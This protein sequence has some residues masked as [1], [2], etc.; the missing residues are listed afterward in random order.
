[1]TFCHILPSLDIRDGALD[2]LFNVYK[3]LL[4][5]FPSYITNH[6]GNVNLSTVDVI[7]AE[8]GAIEDY[9]FSM[10]HDNEERQKQRMEQ[11]RQ[12]KQ[13]AKGRNLDNPMLAAATQSAAPPKVLGKA[14]RILEKQ[15][16]KEEAEKDAAV[17]LKRGH[18]AKEE[19]RKDLKA[20]KMVAEANAKAALE[21]KKSL[22]GGG[23]KEEGEN[24]DGV[25]K[26]EVET[27]KKE[28]QVETA[29][30]EIDDASA[31]DKTEDAQE[32]AGRK[33]KLEDA[34]AESNVEVEK[35]GGDKKEKVEV[36]AKVEVEVEG[37][38]AKIEEAEFEDDVEDDAEAEDDEDADD[39]I[40]QVEV[41]IPPEVEVDPK[42]AAAFKEKVKNAKSKQ[43]DEFAKNVEDNVRLHEKGWKVRCA[44]IVT[45]FL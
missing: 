7:L 24:G 42:L 37:I 2:Y 27:K 36:K 14:A 33:R 30:M 11:Q 13:Q 31:V 20:N 19:A 39:E 40:E 29:E 23:S 15:R 45:M 44:V 17:A 32:S 34:E 25:A 26:D 9:V 10:K 4:P 22:F 16:K 8:V 28:D 18:Q 35:N 38:D 41:E 21:L 6:G 1:M 12:R 43:L 5:T 3:R